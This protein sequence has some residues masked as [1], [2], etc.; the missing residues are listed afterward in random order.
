MLHEIG[1]LDGGRTRPVIYRASMAE[2]V[3]PY[4][5][6]SINHWWKNAFDAGE[7]G[8]GKA[9]NSL[10][11][12]C[13]CLG[14]IVYLDAVQVDENGTA[15]TLSHAV[16]LH[17]EDY[18]ILWKHTDVT[19]GTAETR[20]SRR[21][22]VSSFA[23]VSNYDYGFFWYFYLDGTI[24]A[25]VKLT[26]IIQTQAVRPGTRVPYANPVTPELAGPHH[27]HLFCY[28]LDMCVD[29]RANS[30][31]E[32]DAVPVPQGPDNPYGNAFTAGAT[33]LETESDAQRMAAPERAR[34]WRVVNHG[35]LNACG[36]PV[37]YQLIPQAGAPL[38]AQDTAAITPRAAFATRHLWVTPARPDE[39]RPAGEFPNQHPGGAGLPP[40]PP[41]T[42][43]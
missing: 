28:R 26:G 30:V 42:V 29:G 19:T 2:M 12:G 20:R 18:G 13:D 9:A 33:L 4:G 35:S 16:C 25:E 40:G 21:L 15:S 37:A 36:E 24:A 39:R 6:A 43:R 11:L 22:V 38:L 32:V 34:H 17:E 3:V 5:S 1:Y 27:Q 10:R 8:V 14:E 7:G 23:T 31:Y 41:P